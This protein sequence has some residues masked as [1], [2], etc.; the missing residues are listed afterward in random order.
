LEIQKVDLKKGKDKE[1]DIDMIFERKEN[2]PDI[3][4]P[5]KTL[6]F[7]FFIFCFFLLPVILFLMFFLAI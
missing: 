1:S 3:I 7:I 5:Q 2:F 4:S 6:V